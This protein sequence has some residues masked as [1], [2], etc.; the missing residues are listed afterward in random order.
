MAEALRCGN[1]L[2]STGD[3][4][5]EVQHLCGDP[6]QVNEWEEYRTYSVYDRRTDE[7]IE[8]KRLIVI[9]EWIYNFGPRRFMQQLRFE[10]GKLKKIKRLDYGY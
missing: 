6:E 9:T 2:V 5:S 3:S 4:F 8:R 7:Y 1:Q 10:N